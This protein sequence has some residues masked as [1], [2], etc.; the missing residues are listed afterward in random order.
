L[1]QTEKHAGGL[2]ELKKAR[3]RTAIQRHALR[4]IRE[5]GYAA[6][7]VEQIA[8]AAEVSPSTFFRYF[9]TKEDVVL[10]DAFDPYLVEALRTVPLDVPPIRAIREALRAV[11]A[12]IPPEQR[13]VERERGRLAFS[14]PELRARLVVDMQESLGLTAQLIAERTGHDPRDFEV[15]TLTGAMMGVM[16]ASMSDAIDDPDVDYLELADRALAHLEQGLP[17]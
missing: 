5:Q 4:L 17:L 2:R 6:T 15:R 10:Y 11:L 13:E 8:Q 1:H 12:E 9:P 14:V 7:T 3:T 16:L